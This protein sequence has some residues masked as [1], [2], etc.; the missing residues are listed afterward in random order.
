MQYRFFPLFDTLENHVSINSNV[1]FTLKKT[2]SEIADE[3][4]KL[5]LYLKNYVGSGDTFNTYRREVERFFHW[6]WTIKKISIFKLTPL[7]IGDYIKF[8]RTPPASWCMP[9]QLKRFILKDGIRCPNSMWKPF[10]TGSSLSDNS[11]QIL[12]AALGTMYTYCQ[13]EGYLE[14][15]PVQLM[16]QKTRLIRKKHTVRVTRKLTKT[17]WNLVINTAH[18]LANQNK[19]YERHL[20]LLSAFFLMGVRISELSVTSKH[21]PLMQHFFKDQHDCVWFSTVG[22]GYKYREIAVC[23]AMLDA[24][25]RYR[26]SL[27]LNR[28]PNITESTPLFPKIKG[29][30]GLGV[31]AIRY[32]VQ[33]IFDYVIAQLQADQLFDDA[34]ILKE[35]TVHWLRHT[36]ISLDVEHRPRE[37]VRDDA[38][39]E[40]V[41]ITDRY[42]DVDRA[43]RHASSQSKQLFYSE[44][45]KKANE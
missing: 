7:D 36:S 25:Y 6:S 30:G 5:F 24:L 34:S 42:I 17:Q 26:N 27:G 18:K 45:E 22:K 1:V 10:I 11:L 39:H 2:S 35:A 29:H 38:G 28:F 12:L 20:F 37:H 40:S 8:C 31:R 41:V 19:K 23:D 15:N 13:Q 3:Y 9:K 33:E 4:E 44:D 14:R 32:L 21:A 43:A 16:R